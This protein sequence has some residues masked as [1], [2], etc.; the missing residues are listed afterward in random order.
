MNKMANVT[1][2]KMQEAFGSRPED[3]VAAVGPSICRDCYEVSGDVA[4]TV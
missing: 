2:R 1:V 4:A 3:I